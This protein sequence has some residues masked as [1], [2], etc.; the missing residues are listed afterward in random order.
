MNCAVS[1]RS[2]VDRG[3]TLVEMLLTVAL[4]A[5]AVSVVLPGSSGVAQARVDAAVNEVAAALRFARSDAIRTASFRVAGFDTTTGR[6]HVFA[7]DTTT[8]PPSELTS[9]PVQHP[10]DHKNYDLLL[11][12]SSASVGVVLATVV[13]AFA[14]GSTST[15]LGFDPSGAPVQIQ[16]GGSTLAMTAAMP[17][18]QTGQITVSLAGL[19]R[20]VMVD[21]VTG[22]VTIP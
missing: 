11:T 16:T 10:T 8:S 2:R 1:V 4:L 22:R 5:L 15:Q 19:Q 12:D 13:F 17:P 20:S 21:A 3:F 7:V 14:D 18:G 6:V 9:M